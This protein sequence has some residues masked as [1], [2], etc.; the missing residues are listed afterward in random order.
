MGG[1]GGSD[2]CSQGLLNHVAVEL[3]QLIQ[4]ICLKSALKQVTWATKLHS[5]GSRDVRELR[6]LML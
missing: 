1:V 3:K 5:I 6:D 2:S 4:S